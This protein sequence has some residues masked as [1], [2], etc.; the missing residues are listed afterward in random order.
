MGWL[1]HPVER[2]EQAPWAEPFG[3]PSAAPTV[4][5]NPMVKTAGELTGVTEHGDPPTTH[6]AA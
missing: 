6:I 2:S 5:I 3:P 1:R 4:K